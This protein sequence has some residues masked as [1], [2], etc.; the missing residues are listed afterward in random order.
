MV[1]RILYLVLLLACQVVSAQ[2][3][4]YL[5]ASYGELLD[6]ST[7]KVALWWAS[8]GWKIGTDKPLPTAKSRAITIRAARNETEA[9]QL[10]V[11]PVST[12]TGLTV[13][14]H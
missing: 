5:N 8:S 9:A 2:T 1:K 3:S 14:E 6:D 12:L 4:D 13:R 11:R 10:V 7:G